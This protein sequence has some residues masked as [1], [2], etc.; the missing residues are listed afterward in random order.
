MLQ[1]RTGGESPTL[2]GFLYSAY[3]PT[4]TRKLMQPFS[5][6]IRVPSTRPPSAPGMN[7]ATRW[8]SCSFVLGLLA[9][10]SVRAETY[11]WTGAASSAWNN[12]ANWNPSTGV[13][14]IEDTAIIHSGMPAVSSD[15]TVARLELRGG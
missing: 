13:P 10:A 6:M 5:D 7:T 2:P 11:T 1:N 8:L 4:V 12:P 9:A 15:A 14:S 3:S